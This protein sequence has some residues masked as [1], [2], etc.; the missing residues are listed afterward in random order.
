MGVSIMFSKCALPCRV[1][2]SVCCVY[3]CDFSVVLLGETIRCFD[4]LPP[5][6][7]YF[8]GCVGCACVGLGGVP[9]RQCVVACHGELLCCAFGQLLCWVWVLKLLADASVVSLH[10]Y[11]V[12]VV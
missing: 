4:V 5:G 9:G 3:C 8:G 10:V 1:C 11:P 7:L 12:L 2:V 6:C